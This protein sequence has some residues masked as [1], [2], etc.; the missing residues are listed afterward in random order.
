MTRSRT[1]PLAAQTVLVVD[2][3]AA[4]RDLLEAYLVAQG[5]DVRQARD[6]QEAIEAAEPDLVL[7]DLDMPRLDGLEVCRRIKGHPTRRL[8]PVIIVTAATDHASRLTG[9]EAGADEVLTKPLDPKEL[10]IRSTVLLRERELN[11]RL[12]ATDGVLRAFARAVEAR[13]RHAIYHAERVALYAR[14]I[15]RALHQPADQL[16][17]LY[18]G[19]ML[20]DLGKIAILDA[21]LLKRGPLDEAELAVMRRI[22]SRGRRSAA[23]SEASSG[24]CQ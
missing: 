15:G 24:S 23:R 17:D 11:K 12:D 19:G 5:Y 14:S 10:A 18:L 2:D 20:L 4:N 22:R 16:D 3:V 6:G 7:L 9:L 21:I 1:F 13:D 8:I